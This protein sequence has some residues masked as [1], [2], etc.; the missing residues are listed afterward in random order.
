MA[1][2]LPAFQFYPGDWLKDPA[3]RS[4]SLA[5]RGLWMDI[6]CLMF[7]AVPRGHLVLNG[8]PV[9]V[10]Q[11]ARMVGS[12]AE[13]VTRLMEELL[14]AGV[15]LV[16][17]RGCIYSRRMVR[18]EEI[19]GIRRR[20]GSM[21]G[22]PTLVNQKQVCL[23][24]VKPNDEPKQ[25]QRGK[26]NPTP[27]SSSS[28]SSSSS[29]LEKQKHV[30]HDKFAREIFVYWQQVLHHEK[31]QLDSKRLKSIIA[32]LAEGYA[33]ERIKQAIRG[34]CL[35][36]YHMGK[37]EGGTVY[38]DI[39]LICRSGAHVD[40]FADKE[41]NKGESHGAN[42]KH[43]GR[44]FSR[45]ETRIQKNLAVLHTYGEELGMFER[46]GFSG[47]DSGPVHLLLEHQPVGPADEAMAKSLE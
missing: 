25:K 11:L 37:N 29:K 26:Q 38:D 34:I 27:S 10:E 44:V 32:R 43:S 8:K 14:N 36:P 5:G 17:D 15:A 24:K 45:E 30:E 23:T 19:R 35:S 33:V 31:A 4:V 40:R 18:D 1:G 2:K 13:E 22:N 28:T 6:L 46:E 21:G 12:T 3:L 47:R 20:C 16:T 9:S 42:Q 41:E 7:E 39:E